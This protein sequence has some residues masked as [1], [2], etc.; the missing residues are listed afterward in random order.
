MSTTKTVFAGIGILAGTLLLFFVLGLFGLG[1]FKFFAPKT[2]NI[3]RDV[4]ENTQSYVHGKSQDLAKKFEEYNKADSPAD[5]ETIRQLILLQFAEF[6]ASKLQ[7]P[8]LRNFLIK[9]R[10]Y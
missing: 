4:F 5:R 1:W 7:S 8:E 2:E 6:D 9:M 10:S 3:R